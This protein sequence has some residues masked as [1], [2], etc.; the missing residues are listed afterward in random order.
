MTVCLRTILNGV[1][2]SSSAIH[3]MSPLCH[4]MRYFSIAF[5]ALTVQFT[6]SLVS[7][8]RDIAYWLSRSFAACRVSLLLLATIAI[9]IGI[10]SYF[11]AQPMRY[12]EAYTFLV[13]VNQGIGDLFYYPLP[14]NH[15]LHTLLVRISTT[16]LGSHPV[17]IR[18]P[19]FLAG[20]G[21]IP[22]SFCLAKLLFGERSGLLASALSAVFP[23]L[24]LFD[25]MA[26]GY[27]LVVLLSLCLA[28][29]G[30]R[31]AARQSFALSF[32]ISVISAL[33]ILTMP[34]FFLPVAGIYLWIAVLIIWNSGAK[35]APMRRLLPCVAMTAVFSAVL[36]T[37]TVIVGNIRTVFQN[38]VVVSMSWT[39]FLGRLPNHFSQTIK[40]FCRDVPVPLIVV[41]LVLVGISICSAVRNQRREALLLLPSLAGG[42]LVLLLLK[43]AIPFDR[44][45]IYLLPFVFVFADG[46][47]ACVTGALRTP[48]RVFLHSVLLVLA[49][50]WGVFLMSRGVIASY[51]DT[52]LFPEAPIV[53]D[54]LSREM[55]PGD[56][57]VAKDPADYPIH[58]YMWYKEVPK[59]G[60][61][62]RS[63]AAKE[64][65]IVKKSDYSLHDLTDK[66]AG[67]LMELDDVIVYVRDRSEK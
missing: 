25:T 47:L 34:S 24:I 40:A 1:Y 49:C 43:R 59:S 28:I 55:R 65:F 11:L 15:I 66:S 46:G 51:P 63:S 20:I 54:L 22:A 5:F 52:G 30:L 35:Y 9:A 19:A 23:Y 42:A 7:E 4:L 26:R 57:L 27:S 53:V 8:L 39:E 29:S 3:G 62:P 12:D 64:F 41:L 37:P 56:R 44:T 18:L 67:K 58:F 21:V 31:F 45:W 13:F 16:V 14:N 17:T 60:Q 61:F 10:R 2:G 32:L 50:F 33:G 36:Y 38:P 6:S 48:G